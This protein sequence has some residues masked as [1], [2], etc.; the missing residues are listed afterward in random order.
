MES[1]YRKYKACPAKIKPYAQPSKS[2]YSGGDNSLRKIKQVPLIRDRDE[3]PPIFEIDVELIF[4]DEPR[5]LPICADNRQTYKSKSVFG[6]VVRRINIY[7]R[8][9]TLTNA[10][11][12]MIVTLHLGNVQSTTMEERKGITKSFHFSGTS[13]IECSKI[14]I[15]EKDYNSNN[16][17]Q[18]GSKG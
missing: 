18:D 15:A 1:T 5:K 11:T 12:T 13:P 7:Y 14:L 17:L 10:S 16:N 3:E 9:K 4:F 6:V 8:L 2:R